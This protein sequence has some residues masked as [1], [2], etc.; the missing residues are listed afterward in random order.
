MYTFNENPRINLSQ[1]IQTYPSQT[2]IPKLTL[3]IQ[4]RSLFQKSRETRF[5][6]PVCF[7]D[8][9][10][11]PPLRG[12]YGRWFHGA[13]KIICR[14]RRNHW[15]IR[16]GV[17]YSSAFNRFNRGLRLRRR[18]T[19]NSG[20]KR[21]KVA[22][23]NFSFTPFLFLLMIWRRSESKCSLDNDTVYRESLWPFIRAI[24]TEPYSSF[25]PV[26]FVN[27]DRSFIILDHIFTTFVRVRLYDS[28]LEH[29][30]A[31]LYK[32]PTL[33]GAPLL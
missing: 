16:T 6:I 21:P 14:S 31:R 15:W 9:K 24:Y 28:R 29:N 13:Q 2:S 18:G 22:V 33:V 8:L 1:S 26:L 17:V 5:S 19:R 3:A 7:R 10:N 12:S 20:V 30:N 25:D 4:I 11:C 32:I 23:A 27:S